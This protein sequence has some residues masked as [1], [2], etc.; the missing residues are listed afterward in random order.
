MTEFD[1]E[2]LKNDQVLGKLFEAVKRGHVVASHTQKVL[3]KNKHVKDFCEE[4]RHFVQIGDEDPMYIHYDVSSWF[5]KP[6][7]VSVKIESIG[8]YDNFIEYE[9][10]RLKGIHST[11][12]SDGGNLN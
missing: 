2:F 8:V 7:G 12:D 5:K 10:A 11:P 3:I 1:R 6:M 9:V 4:A